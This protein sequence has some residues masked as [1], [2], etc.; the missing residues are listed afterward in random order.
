VDTNLAN[1]MSNPGIE[2]VPP[3]SA[4]Q[5]GNGAPP[6]GEAVGV[7]K[8]RDLLFGTQMQDYDRRFSQLEERFVQRFRDIESETARNLS[9]MESNAKKQVDSL[10][11]ELRTEKDLRG[12]ADK[13][14]ERTVREH[15]EAIDKRVRALSDQ[16]SQLERD[17]SDRLMQEVQSLREDIKRKNDDTQHM[18][19]KMFA[20]LSN[21][22]TDRNL[23]AGLF[24]EVAKCLNQD[25]APKSPARG[26]AEPTRGW[27]AS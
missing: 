7:D 12:D 15:N 8:I 13:E 17:M 20:E 2:P 4:V 6:A 10:A 19:E 26:G 1:H 5:I 11:S 16:L 22:K 9:A 3:G 14:I 25:V 18:I 24:V 27:P 23:L 21:V